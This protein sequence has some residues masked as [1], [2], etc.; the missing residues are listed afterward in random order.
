MN[1]L[2]IDLDGKEYRLFD[3]TLHNG[4]SLVVAEEAL[5]MHIQRMIEMEQYHKVRRVD[6]MYGYWIPQEVAD[7]ECEEDIVESIEDVYEEE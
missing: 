5:E 2:R 4:K 7:G 3:I 6:E 1:I